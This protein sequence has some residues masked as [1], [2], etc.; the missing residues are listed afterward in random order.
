ML[1][2]RRRSLGEVSGD[3]EEAGPGFKPRS[4]VWSRAASLCPVFCTARGLVLGSLASAALDSVRQPQELGWGW[5]RAELLGEDV[6]GQTG[7]A[8]HI[9]LF[10]LW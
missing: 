10:L 8:A 3:R 6:F 1:Q 2:V 9:G 5:G 4:V 7:R